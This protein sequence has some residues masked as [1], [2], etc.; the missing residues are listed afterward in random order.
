[1]ERVTLALWA[2]LG[3][4]GAVSERFRRWGHWLISEHDQ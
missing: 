2:V 3:Q 1:M 4:M